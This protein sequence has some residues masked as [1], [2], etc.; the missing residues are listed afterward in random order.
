M[1]IEELKLVRLCNIYLRKKNIETAAKKRE[2]QVKQ[3]VK[4]ILLEKTP[5]QAIEMLNDIVSGF[6]TR[7]DEE[8]KTSLESVDAIS[9]FKKLKK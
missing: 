6:N 7:L 5:K 3:I 2:E 9:K 8:L 1:K 4:E